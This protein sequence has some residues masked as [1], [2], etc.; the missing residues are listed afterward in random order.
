MK[1]GEGD[2]YCVNLLFF[3]FKERG[4]GGG[5]CSCLLVFLKK[6]VS[7]VHPFCQLNVEAP[8]SKCVLVFLHRRLLILSVGEFHFF[9]LLQRVS[10]V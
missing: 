10:V 2:C 7:V 6:G 5:H 3:F 4:E 1:E 8:F 9:L